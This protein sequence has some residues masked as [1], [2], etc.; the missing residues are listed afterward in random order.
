MPVGLLDPLTTYPGVENFV[1]RANKRLQSYPCFVWTVRTRVGGA[2]VAHPP[3]FR[4]HAQTKRV[5]TV[6]LLPRRSRRSGPS[7]GQTGA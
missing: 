1:P 7:P 2:T 6:E 5:A 3:A 4:K